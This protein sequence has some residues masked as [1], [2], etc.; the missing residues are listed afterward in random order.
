[1]NSRY[2]CPECNTGK[3]F[4][5]YIDIETGE[6]IADHVGRCNRLDNCSY[7]YTPKQY[8]QDNHIS[9]DTYRHQSFAK[10]KPDRSKTIKKAVFFIPDELFKQSLQ[11]EKDILQT[12]KTNN[13]VQYLL[14]L[15]G[16][17]ITKG[18]IEKYFI[19][20][21][22]HQFKRKEFPNYISEKGATV[23]WQIDN[24]GMIRTGKIMLYSPIT[25]KRIK[26]PYNHISWIHTALKPVESELKQCFFGEHLLRDNTNPVA[27]VESE[28]TAIIAS[29]YLPQLVWLA[30]GN[31][32]G[33]N[34]EKCKV[35]QGRNIIL[36][37]DLNSFE[38]W[39][40][41]A[42]EFSHLA[43]FTVSDLLE[44]KATEAEKKQGLDLADYLTKFN[45]RQFI[46]TG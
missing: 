45:Y 6:Q 30:A 42:K 19:G 28:K 5:R 17:E 37:P 9:F 26:E 10:P 20:T 22:E 43:I 34:T 31:K 27:I 3:T 21:S 11:I 14:Q 40:D 2:R 8:F 18:L 24:V 39:S 35:L 41:K 23:F 12:A 1:M 7:H 16:I 46:E 38:L 13:L 36:F 44:R 32:E 33:L 15:F 29:I 4:S 25:G